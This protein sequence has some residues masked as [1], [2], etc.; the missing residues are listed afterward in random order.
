M[1]LNK[2]MSKFISIKKAVRLETNPV[3]RER[4]IA[5]LFTISGRHREFNRIHSNKKQ[6]FRN[7]A[8]K[9]KY[10]LRLYNR[11]Y[12]RKRRERLI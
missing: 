9:N 12:M 5:Q 7:Y 2:L 10:K 3:K 6:Y 1:R 4:L 8:S 11:E